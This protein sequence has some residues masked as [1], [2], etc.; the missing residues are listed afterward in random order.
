MKINL[1]SI[2]YFSLFIFSVFTFQ[3]SQLDV[4]NNASK[5]ID[6]GKKLLEI[7]IVIDK[8]SIPNG[9]MQPLFAYG[10]FNDLKMENITNYVEWN[11]ISDGNGDVE[12]QDVTYDGNLYKVVHGLSI[13]IVTIFASMDGVTSEGIEI[14]ITDTVLTGIL[15]V[16]P[17]NNPV[18]S[19]PENIQLQFYAT[20]YWSDGVTD[21]ISDQVEWSSSNS[22]VATI[23]IYDGIATTQSYGTTDIIATSGDIS[24]STEL[25]VLQL[26]EMTIRPE[27]ITKPLGVSYN[28]T[29][30]GTFDD[31]KTS[32]I[33]PY[34]TWSSTAGAS[35]TGSGAAIGTAL[36]TATISATVTAQTVKGTADLYVDNNIYVST[37]GSDTD[38]D[39]TIANDTPT[40]FA[41][42]KH[43]LEIAAAD[44]GM[45]IHVSEGTYL[46]SII[47]KND[48]CLYGGYSSDFS[49]RDSQTFLTTI[50]PI[51]AA[52]SF[53]SVAGDGTITSLT[54]IDGFIING[55]NSSTSS[56]FGILCG[57]GCSP[58]ITN[59]RIYGGTGNPASI[60]IYCDNDGFPLIHHNLING[61]ESN[62]TAGIYLNNSNAA[63]HENK[64]FGGKGA[65]ASSGIAVRG[66]D[67]S[68]SSPVIRNNLIHG[69][70]STYTCG[71]DVR[72]NTAIQNNTIYGGTNGGTTSDV[73]IG[74]RLELPTGINGVKI[75][76][77]IIFCNPSVIGYG[78]YEAA[79][80]DIVPVDNNNVF[81]CMTA[82]Y[83]ESY[84]TL[85]K[86]TR[87]GNFF[88]GGVALTPAGK[89]NISTPLDDS[90]FVN[91]KG[92]DADIDT[93][94]DSQSWAL[95]S[96]AEPTTADGGLQLSNLDTYDFAGNLRTKPWSIGA[97]ENDSSGLVAF[98][99]LK[100][101]AT[102]ESASNISG[103]IIDG[104]SYDSAD[105][106]GN[107]ESAF[108]FDGT[109][110]IEVLSS[111]GLSLPLPTGARAR[112]LCTWVRYE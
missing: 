23:D 61:G 13:G 98:Y 60:G 31:C 52:A 64:I 81:D 9:L 68:T 84:G 3:C 17:S 29:A 53:Y 96:P 59:N 47:L 4:Y 14:E 67:G 40:P 6:P 75:Q 1:K 78:I 21:D 95:S 104:L 41:T 46:D 63:V 62:A 101:D 108:H 110:Y 73:S 97:Y 7:S 80:S 5:E 100:G 18:F 93:W 66:S 10:S 72:Y 103:K 76:N 86:G 69:G 71:L 54:V 42:I 34:V 44:K 89:G 22:A 8:S 55:G 20:G 38:G 105:R 82:L 85:F 58:T 15:V 70:A 88:E 25:T 16:G 57:P 102:D 109:G 33:T 43:A 99:P 37:A 87:N 111:T 35:I 51:S 11:Y 19:I 27:N 30:T 26:N 56:T 91:L 32:D 49:I 94:D 106:Y 92:S 39:G 107:T 79:Q 90:M 24:S 83:R 112:T 36:G 28:F 50:D 2:K 77:N 48:V 45:V 12:F 74:I 65:A